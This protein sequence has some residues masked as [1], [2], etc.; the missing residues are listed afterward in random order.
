[1]QTTVN[2]LKKK[3]NLAGGTAPKMAWLQGDIGL[4]QSNPCCPYRRGVS[5]LSYWFAPGRTRLY[6]EQKD[7][8]DTKG[9]VGL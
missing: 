9:I 2:K 1:M 5:R 6:A 4:K 3:K 8:I 7:K